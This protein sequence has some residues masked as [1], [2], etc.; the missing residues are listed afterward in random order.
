M[1][2]NN[3]FITK[4]QLDFYQVT[5]TN[6]YLD[7]WASQNLQR[8]QPSHLHIENQGVYEHS[9]VYSI[10]NQTSPFESYKHWIEHI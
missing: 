8:W 2:P 6:F 7:R 4:Y 1:S 9:Q 10:P 5:F 3:R